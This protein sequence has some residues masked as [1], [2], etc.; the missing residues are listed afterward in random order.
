MKEK[1]HDCT[2]GCGLELSEETGAVVS[3]NLQSQV[4]RNNK[5]GEK[6]ESK[7]A[8]CARARE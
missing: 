2:R 6:Q 7:V 1:A 5:G 8:L 3:I 4:F